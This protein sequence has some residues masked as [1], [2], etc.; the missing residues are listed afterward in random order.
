[1]D[2][3]TVILDKILAAVPGLQQTAR[4]ATASVDRLTA[5]VE[6]TGYLLASAMAAIVLTLLWLKRK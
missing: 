2:K 4:G 3:L 5:Q 6:A 1:M